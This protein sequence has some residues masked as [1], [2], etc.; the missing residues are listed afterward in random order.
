ML[1]H[2]QGG[3]MARTRNKTGVPMRIKV[4]DVTK[5]LIEATK[6]GE[7]DL[8]WVGER[9]GNILVRHNVDKGCRLDAIS[10]DFWRICDALKL[11]RTSFSHLRD[12]AAIVIEGIDKSLTDSFLGHADRRMATRYVDP[13]EIDTTKLDKAIDQLERHFGLKWD[14]PAA[15]AKKGERDAA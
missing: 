10:K 6:N 7:G 14:G 4:W 5:R 8:I 13:R 12:T 9:G 3:Y 15:E 11:K 1:R 2:L